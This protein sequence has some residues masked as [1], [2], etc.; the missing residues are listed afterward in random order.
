MVLKLGEVPVG[1]EPQSDAQC[2]R[3]GISCN[4][5]SFCFLILIPLRDTHKALC[6]CGPSL[7]R[8]F[9]LL[10]RVTG[11]VGHLAS[12]YVLQATGPQVFPWVALRCGAGQPVSCLQ[13]GGVSATSPLARALTLPVCCF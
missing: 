7:P 4:K 11:W 13:P 2:R 6:I 9:E 1:W 12:G 5:V 10:L 8:I 3:D